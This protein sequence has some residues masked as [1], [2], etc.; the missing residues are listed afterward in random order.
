MRNRQKVNSVN[1]DSS[2]PCEWI[3]DLL[4]LIMKCYY[5]PFPMF[6][7]DLQMTIGTFL[8]VFFST[9]QSKFSIMEL[10]TFSHSTL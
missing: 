6:L 7:L 1:G 9:L 10:L 8:G 4:S 5:V 3:V 2:S